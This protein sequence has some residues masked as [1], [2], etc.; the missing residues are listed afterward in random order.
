MKQQEVIKRIVNDL[1]DISRRI[2]LIN[3]ENFSDKIYVA[4]AQRGVSNAID[5]LRQTQK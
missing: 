1:E 2:E 3:V 4:A 5:C